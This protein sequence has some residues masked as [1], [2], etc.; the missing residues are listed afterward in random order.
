MSKNK[1]LFSGGFLFG[2]SCIT[3]AGLYFVLTKYNKNSKP[4][5]KPKPPTVI[6]TKNT[7]APKIPKSS[8]LPKPEPLSLSDIEKIK[9][10]CVEKIKQMKMREE[11]LIEIN[12]NPLRKIST[13]FCFVNKYQDIATIESPSSSD[14]EWFRIDYEV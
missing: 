13:E 7:S 11:E 9:A 2:A 4:K 1:N 3:G 10:V 14:N 12:L 5:K 8:E 6:P